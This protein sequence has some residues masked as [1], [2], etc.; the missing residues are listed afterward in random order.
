M[1]LVTL[2]GAEDLHLTAKVCLLDRSW[3]L[4]AALGVIKDAKIISTNSLKPH[5]WGLKT[6]SYIR[7]T[8][9]CLFNKISFLTV[10]VGVT[11]FLTISVGNLGA[12]CFAVQVRLRYSVN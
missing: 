10:A 12:E 4:A 5:F 2:F 1:N 7:S 8:V 3:C 6:C 11:K 9:V